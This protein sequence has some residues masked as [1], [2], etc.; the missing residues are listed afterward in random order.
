[1]RSFMVLKPI[2]AFAYAHEFGSRLARTRDRPGERATSG[3][4]E[5]SRVFAT[6]SDPAT[7]CGASVLCAYFCCS[8]YPKSKSIAAPKSNLL[9]FGSE[10]SLKSTMKRFVFRNI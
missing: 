2:H 1:M 5:R 10:T 3:R 4:H 7:H 6:R 8:K 9:S